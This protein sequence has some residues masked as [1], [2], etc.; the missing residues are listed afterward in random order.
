M[1]YSTTAQI[2]AMFRNFGAPTAPA[3]TDPSV[4]EFIAEADQEIDAAL[5]GVYTLP[6]AGP[7]SL[8]LLRKISRL[9]AAAVVDDILNT[10]SEADKKPGYRRD[11]LKMLEDISGK[12]DPKTGK[13]TLPISLLPDA[14]YIGASVSKNTPA[15]NPQDGR[16]FQ[17]GVDAW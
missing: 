5:T 9:L 4:V 10:Y 17:K 7:L 1:S 16:Q 13:K 11:A 6:I 8:L 2:K 15:I 14:E 12:L 3:V